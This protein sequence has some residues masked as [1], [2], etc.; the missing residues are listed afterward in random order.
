M[1][2]NPELKTFHASVLVTYFVPPAAK[3]AQN[4]NWNGLKN[5]TLQRTCLNRYKLT[6]KMAKTIYN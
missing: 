5:R 3:P 4:T 6:F 2:M 1:W